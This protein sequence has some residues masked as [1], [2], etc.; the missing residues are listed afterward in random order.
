MAYSLDYRKRAI[1]LLEEGSS[2]QEL[3]KMLGVDRKTLY[4]WKKRE[5][6]GELETNYPARRGAYR[7]N[8]AALKAHIEEHP[9]AYLAELAVIA[10]GSV[11]GVRHALKRLGITRKKRHL[12]TVSVMNSNDKAI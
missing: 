1:E 8:E 7:I 9:D 5:E 11:E 12:S 3:S 2:V 4:N 10:G 6:R